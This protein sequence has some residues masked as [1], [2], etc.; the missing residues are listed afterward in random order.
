MACCRENKTRQNTC[1]CSKKSRSKLH[2]EVCKLT[3][4]MNSLS[5]K[6][7][8]RLCFLLHISLTNVEICSNLFGCLLLYSNVSTL[9]D[10]NVVP[11]RNDPQKRTK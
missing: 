1:N 4:S 8:I 5:S 6:F 9:S 11:N 7:S 10:L 2:Q 3:F